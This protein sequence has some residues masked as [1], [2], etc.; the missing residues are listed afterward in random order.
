MLIHI[1]FSLLTTVA[2]CLEGGL[3]DTATCIETLQENKW[4]NKQVSYSL[5]FHWQ[6]KIKTILLYQLSSENKHCIWFCVPIIPH[7][8]CLLITNN[9]SCSWGVALGTTEQP[10]PWHYAGTRGAVGQQPLK[11]SWGTTESCY[12]QITQLSVGTAQSLP[13]WSPLGR[14]NIKA[15]D[16][17]FCH[18]RIRLL[19]RHPELNSVWQV[20]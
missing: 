10:Q 6:F 13:Q 20:I 14:Y 15:T 3:E 17:F 12:L 11:K 5:Y 7:F 9:I 2:T 4:S 19:L 18:C 1:S 16:F 8:D